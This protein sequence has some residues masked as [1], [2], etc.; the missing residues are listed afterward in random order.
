MKRQRAFLVRRT[1]VDPAGGNAGRFASRQLFR[2]LVPS[3]F[4]RMLGVLCVDTRE[5]VFALTYDDGPD[6][7]HTPRILEVLARHGARATFFVM[8]DRAVEHD[9]IVKKIIAGGHEV[10]VHGRDHESMLTRGVGEFWRHVRRARRDLES[11]GVRPTLYRP[12][13]MQFRRG[14]MMA[15]RLSGLTLAL[16]SGDSR[17]WQHD[18]EGVIAQR[19]AAAVFPG[20]VLLM[21][22]SRADP[23]TARSAAELPRFDRADVIDR[24]LQ[25]AAV[26]GLQA[27]TMTELLG[28]GAAVAARAYHRGSR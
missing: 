19:G 16:A 21:H 17:D 10:Q 18:D 9:D 11:V 20:A 28:R 25:A 6:P 26:R 1:D 15:V 14:Q 24:L 13:Y 27:V 12:P 3:A 7:D 4:A 8:T 5:P 22:D 23:E 2:G